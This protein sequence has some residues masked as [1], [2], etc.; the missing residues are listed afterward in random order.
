MC[1]LLTVAGISTQ[2][3]PND[4]IGR[5]LAERGWP[6]VGARQKL[7]VLNCGTLLALGVDRVHLLDDS[8]VS[9]VLHR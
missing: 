4:L 1:C 2:E 8:A 3:C 6:F 5:L 9:T 7:I